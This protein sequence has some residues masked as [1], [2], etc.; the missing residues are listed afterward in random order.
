MFM[1]F[2]PVP[3]GWWSVVPIVGQ[4]IVIDAGVRGAPAVSLHVV[5][6]GLVTAV[7]AWVPLAAAGRV[8]RRDD[9]AA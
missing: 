1:V 7:C 6:L 2:F 8:L 4:Q 3:D 5:G 9:L